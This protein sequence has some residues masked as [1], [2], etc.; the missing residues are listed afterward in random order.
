MLLS[1]LDQ[2]NLAIKVTRVLTGHTKEKSIIKDSESH[3]S[4]STE[5][6]EYEQTLLWI[7]QQPWQQDLM[8]QHN[9]Y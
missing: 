2:E 5:I 4:I 8:M 6:L 9:S 7:Y 1:K 3:D